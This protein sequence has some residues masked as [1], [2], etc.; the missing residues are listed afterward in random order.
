MGKALGKVVLMHTLDV[1]KGMPT[2]VL[3][4]D[5]TTPNNSHHTPFISFPLRIP[6]WKIL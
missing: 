1:V 4:Q 6:A 3:S 2:V 5:F